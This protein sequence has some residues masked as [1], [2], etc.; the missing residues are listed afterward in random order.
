MG[1]AKVQRN[2]GFEDRLARI[3]KGGANTMGAVQ[4]GPRDEKAAMNGTADN[5]VTLKRKKNK[6]A[7]LSDGNSSVLVPLAVLLGGVSMFV[8]QAAA[9][10]L[11]QPGG[12][13]P[14]SVPVPALETYVPFAHL[15]FGSILALM[16]AYTF[17]LTKSLRAIALVGGMVAVVHF[18]AELIEQFPGLYAGLFSEEFVAAAPKPA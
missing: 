1:M 7:E 14:I 18:Q 10:H 16:F 15:L 17:R 6:K 12:L 13:M 2:N 9:Y 4:I 8:G 3:Q 11:F 5:T